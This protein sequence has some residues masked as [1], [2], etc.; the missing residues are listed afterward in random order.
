MLKGG[1]VMDKYNIIPNNKR[2]KLV[3]SQL[4]TGKTPHPKHNERKG[5]LVINLCTT[6]KKLKRKTIKMV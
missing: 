1:K 4:K 6:K 2:N 5:N 3:F